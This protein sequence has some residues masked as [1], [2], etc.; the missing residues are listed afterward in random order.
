MTKNKQTVLAQVRIDKEIYYEISNVDTMR[1]FFMSILSD[2]NHWMF[3]GS[4]GGLTAGRKDAEQAL[5][6]YYTD[7]KIIES[8]E[9]TGSKTIFR[10]LKE[11]KSYLW[12]PFSIR[13]NNLYNLQRN[14]YKSARGNKIVFEEVN[15]DLKLTFQYK[16]STSN[17]YGFVK[18]SKLIN[19]GPVEMNIS[20]IDGIQNILPYGVGSALQKQSSNLVD[21]YKRNELDK[22]TGIGI[23]ALSAIIVD[24]PEPSEALKSTIVW[25][26]GLDNS[27]RLLSSTQLDN[28]RKESA[29]KQELDIKAEKGAYFVQADISLDS[30][31][32]KEWMMVADVN[33]NV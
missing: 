20:V 26:I 19:E 28:F 32:I 10:I 24:K 18:S 29:I 31:S 15:H 17:F 30:K 25:S 9:I 33:Q 5:F 2:S 23:F 16:W 3:I 11:N 13:C 8:T 4:N 22:D 14:L 1:P 27:K 7:D 6:P 21:A 12:E